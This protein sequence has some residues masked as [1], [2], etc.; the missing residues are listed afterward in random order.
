MSNPQFPLY[1]PSKGR[2]DSR[3]TS[4]A[5]EFMKVPY[6]IIVEPQEYDSY[7][8]VIDPAKILVLPDNYK[9]D[10]EL[11]DTLGLTKSTGPGP[12]RNF[13]W[14]HSISIGARWHWVMD[15]N[16]MSFKMFQGNVKI[17]CG[18]GTI[19]K[20]MED[21][22]LRYDN[23]AMAGP[24]YTFFIPARNKRPPF[25]TNTRIYSCN[26]IRNDVPFRW[27]GRYNEDTILS[28]DML[29]A[30][31]ATVQFNMF[32][33]E[34]AT[35]QTV[36]GG[37]DA[38]FYSVEGTAP[39]S[40]MLYDVHPDI[41]VLT[42]RYGRAHHH[43]DYSIFKQRLNRRTDIAFPTTQNEYGFHLREV[44]PALFLSYEHTYED[45]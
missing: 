36:K 3:F 4:R 38:D 18:D 37:N 31:W 34:K 32:L 25:I 9:P 22:V 8:A 26:L 20:C 10:Y 42:D 35:T 41:T 12:A 14:D 15:D 27:R 2:A 40:Q 30:D 17:R 19:F 1:I 43:I 39:K 23:I 21:F 7:A 13:A 16:I 24:H 11:C 45:I 33:Q 6:Y 28:V 44:D 29:K 5:L